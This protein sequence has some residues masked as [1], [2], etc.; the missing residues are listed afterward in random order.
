MTIVKELGLALMKCVFRRA[1][2]QRCREQLL[3]SRSAHIV[4]APS[5]SAS[6]TSA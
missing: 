5:L 4:D 2:P 6:H 1:E 3:I